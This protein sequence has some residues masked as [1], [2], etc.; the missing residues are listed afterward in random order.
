MAR[1]VQTEGFARVL[2]DAYYTRYDLPNPKPCQQRMAA[3]GFP[4]DS[5]LRL[6][7][8]N[9][10]T[11]EAVQKLGFNSIDEY[12]E[13]HFPSPPNLKPAD[14][15]WTQKELAFKPLPRPSLY[16]VEQS[17]PGCEK[18]EAAG[19]FCETCDAK[20]CVVDFCMNFCAPHS[21]LCT[22]DH[23]KM[24]SYCVICN[25]N[26]ELDNMFC[27]ECSESAANGTSCLRFNCLK[28][29]IQGTSLCWT[30]NELHGRSRKYCDT[31]DCYHLTHCQNAY[32]HWCVPRT[33][34]YNI[35]PLSCQ[36]GSVYLPIILSQAQMQ[37][38]IK[39]VSKNMDLLELA[40]ENGISHMAPFLEDDDGILIC[41][42]STQRMN[43]WLI[44]YVLDYLKNKKALSEDLYEAMRREVLAT[45]RAQA[46][47]YAKS[48]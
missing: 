2:E 25:T 12:Y 39:H 3:P 31:T 26:I 24:N 23:D 16:R 11:P 9:P 14:A 5:F 42:E 4:A 34:Q 43:T 27:N 6:L 17:C 35:G 44:Y 45:Q 37:C 20:L 46:N 38:I 32:C 41:V 22:E 47:L 29:A 40:R 30:C 33:H 1:H 18:Y 21:K 13:S 15:P 19:I 36:Q 8:E 10:L 7:E 28:P 48:R